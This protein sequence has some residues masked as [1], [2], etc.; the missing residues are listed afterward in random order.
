MSRYQNDRLSTTGGSEAATQPD[1]HYHHLFNN[2]PAWVLEASSSTHSA[3][4]NATLMTPDW[5]GTAT[6]QQHQS[7]KK[8]SQEHWTHRNRLDS[9]LSKLQNAQAFAE[10]L[11]SDALK[12]R[13][14]L[15]L[16]VKT[17]FL[18]LYIPQTAPFFGIKTG[19]ARTW[20]VSML[21]AAL[22]NFQESELSLIH[23]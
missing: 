17:T 21:D 14:D 7:L 23:I 4:K 18:R 10:P 12:T 2:L 6:P 9:M 1:D 5:H 20:T 19:A 8:I 13:F 16:D 3:L 11:L 15:D 22:H